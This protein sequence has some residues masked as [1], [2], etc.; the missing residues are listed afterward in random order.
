MENILFIW[1]GP[2]ENYINV[3][4]ESLRLYN[5]N[6]EIYFYYSNNSII[7]TYKKYNITFIKIDIKNNLQYKKI[8][9]SK[10]LCECLELNS[11]ILILDF[12]IL[13]QNNPFLMFEQYPN[14]DF[15]YTHYIMSTP[16]SLRPEELWK[17][18]LYKVNGGVWGLIVNENSKKLM[19][20]WIDN[21]LNEKWEP[22][23]KYKPRQNRIGNLNWDVDQDFLNCID[24][25]E[26]PFTLKKVN[27][28]Y[29]YNYFVSTW[30]HFNKKLN[31][32]NKIGN[33]DYVIIHFKANFKDTYNLKNPNIYNIKN[34][35]EKKD[36]TS[37]ES[38]E[39]I[40]NKFISRGDKRFFIV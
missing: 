40:Y 4:L 35:L 36:L 15:Y 29:K 24:L 25:Y 8:L 13:F 2:P 20:F 5:K 22:W 18:V 33:S 3:C 26:L 11:K 7:D 30:G 21:L 16:D 31:M 37:P 10:R 19:K 1:D 34:I 39:R 38:R 28:G 23:K 6:C 17:S 27:V 32:G 12:D 9:I 14:N